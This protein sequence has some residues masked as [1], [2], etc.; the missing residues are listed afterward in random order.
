[1]LEEGKKN[2]IA[3]FISIKEHEKKHDEYLKKL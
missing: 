3:D 2:Y 1:M